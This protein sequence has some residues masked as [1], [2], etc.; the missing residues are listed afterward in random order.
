VLDRSSHIVDLG[1]QSLVP[2]RAGQNEAWSLQP[3]QQVMAMAV[4]G[5]VLV[6]ARLEQFG[7]ELADRFEEPEAPLTGGPLDDGHQRLLDQAAQ[8]AEKIVADLGGHRGRGVE[9]EAAA[10]H[11]EPA[12]QAPRPLL[13]LDRRVGQNVPLDPSRRPEGEVTLWL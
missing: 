9:D 1:G 12:E 13:S 11:G 4:R 5:V 7:G 10:E 3:G 8:G 2:V 6:A